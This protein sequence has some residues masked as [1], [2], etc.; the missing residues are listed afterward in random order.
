MGEE[1]CANFQDLLGNPIF[2]ELEIVADSECSSAVAQIM[3]ETKCTK[4]VQCEGIVDLDEVVAVPAKNVE[5]LIN[6]ITPCDPNTQD[7]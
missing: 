1:C 3:M 6:F 7:W 5:W 4:E 2:D